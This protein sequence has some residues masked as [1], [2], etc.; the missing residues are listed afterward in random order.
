MAIPAPTRT[1]LPRSR[2]ACRGR[3]HPRLDLSRVVLV[4]HSAGGHFAL[5]AAS[6]GSVPAA[7]PLHGPP[8]VRAARRDQPGR[9]GR[10]RDFARFV[11]VLC[12]PGIGERLAP[13]A[14]L[15][16]VSPAALT[17]SAGSV[18]MVI[19]RLHRLVPP[20]VAYDYARALRGRV[21]TAPRLVDV[22]DAGHFDL[23][24]P[25]T[26]AWGR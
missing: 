8:P 11:P 24:T 22:P 6:R 26:P 17:P 15:A 7:S 2:P 18:V 19:G 14:T 9:R 25:C 21:A 3:A 20:W 4:G 23:V 5:W 10:T 12:G 1:S 13:A 16:E